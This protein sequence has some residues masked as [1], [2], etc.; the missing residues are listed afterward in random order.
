MLYLAPIED[1]DDLSERGESFILPTRE[2]DEYKGFQ[3]K[4][5]EVEFWKQI[6][7]G[8]VLAATCSMFDSMDIEIY[9]P[10]LVCYFI[11]MTVFLCRVKIE[12]MIRYKYIPFEIGKKKY[13]K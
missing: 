6:F 9:W 10:L 12:H 4:L 5:G 3:R 8:T 11:I 1:P 2:N 7:G 13:V